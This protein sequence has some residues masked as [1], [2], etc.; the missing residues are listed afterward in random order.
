VAAAIAALVVSLALV[1]AATANI[2][3]LGN[4]NC[5]RN[6]DVSQ[7]TLS[8]KLKTRTIYK[9]PDG[10]GTY[11]YRKRSKL[12]IFKSGPFKR[13]GWYGKHRHLRGGGEP[14]IELFGKVGGRDFRLQCLPGRLN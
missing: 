13:Y 2:P 3:P 8:F 10:T 4:Y 9:T 6:G 14:S 5:Y 1:A 7:Y 11:R 12:L